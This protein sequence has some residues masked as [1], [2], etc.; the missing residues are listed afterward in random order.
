MH[1]QRIFNNEKWYVYFFFPYLFVFVIQQSN[2]FICANDIYGG[3][4]ALGITS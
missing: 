4:M 3:G 2:A 1:Q